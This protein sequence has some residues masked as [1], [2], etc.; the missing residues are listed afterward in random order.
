MIP[1]EA[2]VSILAITNFGNF[3]NYLHRFGG[4]PALKP[5]FMMQS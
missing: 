1:R 5:G 2:E 3:G 4:C